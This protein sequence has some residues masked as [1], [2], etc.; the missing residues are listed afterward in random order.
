MYLQFW[1]NDWG[2]LHATGVIDNELQSAQKIKSGEE[3]SAIVPAGNQ[4][5]NLSIMNP[6]LY[7]LCVLSQ[8]S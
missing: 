2:L 3:N 8:L 4:T 5:C 1:Q 7:E 6:V